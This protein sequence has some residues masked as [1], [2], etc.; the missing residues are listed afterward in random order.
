MTTDEEVA[1]KLEVLELK[2]RLA[3]KDMQLAALAA[4]WSQS[5]T[6]EKPP[7]REQPKLKVFKNPERFNKEDLG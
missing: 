4:L 2:K 3:E 7:I 1:L 6:A 5:R